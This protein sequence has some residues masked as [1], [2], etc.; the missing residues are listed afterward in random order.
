MTGR[1]MR[2]VLMPG[3]K[4]VE[5]VDRPVPVPGPRDVLVKTRASAICRSDMSIYYGTPVL[6]G[7]RTGDDLRV[8]GHEAAGIV[9]A[10]GAEVTAVAP[11]DRVASYLAVG[12]SADP[13]GARGYLMLTPGW[14]CFGFDIDGGDADYF[15]L[16]EQNCLPLPDGLSFEAGAVATDMIGT[17]YFTQKRLGVRAGSAV[18][19]IG[20]GPMGSAAIM[21]AKAHG[22]TVIAVDVLQ[23]RLDHALG[24]GADH[25]VNSAETDFAEAVFALTGGH[26]ADF[27]VECSGNSGAQSKA[28]DAA[29]KLGAVAF[30]GESQATT[31][32]PSEQ[33]IHKQLTLIGG[34][35][36]PRP[37]WDGIIAFVLEHGLD[38]ERLISHRFSL[39]QAADAFTAFDQRL[40][41]KAVFVWPEDGTA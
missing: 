9:V 1:T 17:Q 13:Y 35:Y 4:R 22:A 34:W 24:L 14:S 38:I 28:L 41:D 27:V 6:G 30:V 19:V 11:G 20:L 5:V 29:A 3:E 32:N 39:E 36:F 25:A 8:P 37:E 33:M 21:I 40:T 10:V 12:D 16:P 23:S 26:G 15:L 7:V 2:A 18:A 31:I